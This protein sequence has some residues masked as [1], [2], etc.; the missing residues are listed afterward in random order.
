MIASIV[1]ALAILFGTTIGTLIGG[2]IGTQFRAVVFSGV[3]VVA[4]LIGVSMALESQ[5]FLYLVLSLVIGGLLG[6]AWRIEDRVYQLGEWLKRRF[7][8]RRAPGAVSAPE[9]ESASTHSFAQGF[10]VSSVLFCVGA[11]AIIGSF[12]AGVEGDY[13]IL[14]TKSVMD[15]FMAVL[16]TAAYGIGVG[17]SAG[18]VLLY[19][20]ALTLLAGLIAPLVSP[21][22]VSEISGVG[23]AMVVM[24]GLNLLELRTIKTAD[25]LPGLV[26]VVLFVLADPIIGQFVL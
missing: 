13:E 8:P 7:Q 5:R 25:F 20:G 18:S 23:G 21:L 16:L 3:G 4:L 24:I 22:M 1:N 2:R 26:I 10:L 6:T 17:F 19:Q 12:Q 11:L 14:F 9:E 15:G